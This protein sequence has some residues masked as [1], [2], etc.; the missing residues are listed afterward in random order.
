MPFLT[1]RLPCLRRPPRHNCGADLQPQSF[2]FFN[3][4]EPIKLVDMRLVGINAKPYNGG[5]STEVYTTLALTSDQA[6]FQ[7]II[8][9]LASAIEHN[10]QQVGEHVS[11]G[12]ANTVL[13][14]QRADGTGELWIDKAA[15]CTYSTLK[16]PGPLAA[17]TVLFEAD[18]ADITG[19]WFPKVDIGPT[20]RVL[21][22]IREGWR[23]GLY[24]DFR[25]KGDFSVQ[26]ATQTLGTLYRRM[27]FADLYAAVANQPTFDGLVSAGWFPFLEIVG[28]EFKN[29]MSTHENGFPLKDT[30]HALIE[31]FDNPRLD[32]MFS[33]WMEK[34]SLKAKETILR[35]ALNAY[36]AKEPVSV[37]KIILTE[38]EGVM[39]EA[40]F[41][42]KG[43]R[44]RQMKKLLA[45]M[46]DLAEERA[47]GKDTLFFPAD[48]GRYLVRYTYRNF[49]P[50]DTDSG[51]SRHA[52]GHGAAPSDQYDMTRALQAILTLDQLAFYI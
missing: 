31:K 32:R 4:G 24:F 42:V 49:E 39:A 28:N 52:V 7:A 19:V 12:R 21:C 15:M 46:I 20:D 25:Q 3:L 48:F 16:R 50:G 47:G 41:H 1:R 33:R 38:I 14:V 43:E 5:G 10:A 6:L 36:Q 18:I 8:G 44:T 22:I 9:N 11:L 35:P 34:P 29:L 30:E 26:E 2:D 51:G 23:F 45:F 27:R 37:I 40:Y 13:M 17:G